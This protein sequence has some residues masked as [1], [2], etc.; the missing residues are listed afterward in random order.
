MTFHSVDLTSLA[1]LLRRSGSGR[2]GDSEDSD[3]DT[4]TKPNILPGSVCACSSIHSA[5]IY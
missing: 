2:D 3:D 1:S 4:P 5:G